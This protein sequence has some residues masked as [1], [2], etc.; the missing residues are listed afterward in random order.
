MAGEINRDPNRIDVSLSLVSDQALEAVRKLTAE[1]SALHG[2]VQAQSEGS[3]ASRIA[4]MANVAARTAAV[5]QGTGVSHAISPG[6]LPWNPGEP[7]PEGQGY[8]SYSQYFPEG[9]TGG[10]GGGQPPKPPP[11]VT[12][13]GGGD[14]EPKLSRAEQR[15]AEEAARAA[16]KAQAR[17]EFTRYRKQLETGQRFEDINPEERMTLSPGGARYAGHINDWNLFWN[18]ARR[19]SRQGYLDDDPRYSGNRW[20]AALDRFFELR[21]PAQMVPYDDYA[22]ATGQTE[23]GGQGQPMT[24][25]RAGGFTVQDYATA[26]GRMMGGRGGRGPGSGFTVPPGESFQPPVPPVRESGAGSDV[27][28]M[29]AWYG[30]LARSGINPD[31]RAAINVPRFGQFTIQDQL[32][33]IA[34]YF[35]ARAMSN[36]D[37][38]MSEKRETIDALSKRVEDPN[39]EYGPEHYQAD[40]NNIIGNMPGRVE[41]RIANIAQYGRENAAFAVM[42]QQAVRNMLQF[43]RN[44]EV[45][46]ELQGFARTGTGLGGSLQVA[47]IGIRSPLA[48]TVGAAIGEAGEALGLDRVPLIG[49]LFHQMGSPAAREGLRQEVTRRRVQLAAGVSGEEAEQIMQQTRALGYSGDLNERLQLDVF[50]HLQQRG[51]G[52]DVAAPLVDQAIRQGINNLCGRS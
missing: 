51:I 17:D 33:M 29:P 13:S 35:G 38:Y 46:G 50:R 7:R 43:S 44:T 40:V 10:A 34:E 37:Q 27:S 16:G 21:H 9:A 3:S 14:E 19:E 24:V 26:A 28:G 23:Y 31:D 20:V 36:A 48:G 47:G 2:F 6:A 52:A 18:V 15:R 39:D 12:T 25:P 11:A 4:G 8:T 42:G 1:L 5:T 45:A 22:E 32:A 49:G 30:G 41:G